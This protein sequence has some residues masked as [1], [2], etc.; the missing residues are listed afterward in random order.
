MLNPQLLLLQ[1]NNFFDV[2]EVLKILDWQANSETP[3]AKL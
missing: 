1:Y 2:N 3:F